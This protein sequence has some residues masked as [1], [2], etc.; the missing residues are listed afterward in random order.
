MMRELLIEV[1]TVAL[2]RLNLKFKVPV[3]Y[4]LGNALASLL[5]GNTCDLLH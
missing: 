1:T 3:S 2:Q 5:K 4:S